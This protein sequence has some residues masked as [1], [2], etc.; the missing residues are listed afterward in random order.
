[1]DSA[2][3]DPRTEQ[4]DPT[5]ENTTPAYKPKY[6]RLTDADRS[7]I[8]ALHEQKLTQTEIA[9]RIGCTQ[10]AVSDWLSA[11]QDRTGDATLYLRGQALRMARKVA[12]TKDPKALV[13]A[14]KGVKVLSDDSQ[15]SVQII[16]GGGSTVNIGPTFASQVATVSDDMHKL[17]GD[18]ASNNGD[19]VVNQQPK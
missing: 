1:M 17:T 13:A 5:A 8:L 16:V 2:L 6:R 11:C 15:Q 14:L 19:Y 9:Q 4:A 3:L 10:P 12:A 18:V 7:Y